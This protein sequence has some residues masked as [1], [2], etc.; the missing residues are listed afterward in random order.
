MHVYI[1]STT[2]DL[3]KGINQYAVFIL[4]HSIYFILSICI[5]E[6]RL[7]KAGAFLAAQEEKS[8]ADLDHL[9]VDTGTQML[10]M[11]DTSRG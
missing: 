11:T 2:V 10:Y 4:Y 1:L 5:V 9:P 8:L 3:V 6:G 7:S